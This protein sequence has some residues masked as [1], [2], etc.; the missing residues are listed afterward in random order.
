MKLASAALSALLLCSCSREPVPTAAPPAP[1]AP[2]ASAAPAAEPK[3]SRRDAGPAP[4]L[5]G[6]AFKRFAKGK[7]AEVRRCY[8]AALGN[9]PTLGGKVTI[10]FAILPSG[11][12]SG[13]SVAR[14][15]FRR[16]AVPTCVAAVVRGWRTPF[17]PEEA[18]TVEYP[19]SFAP[20][21]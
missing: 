4:E 5:T 12:V 16:D 14:S 17:R 19:L 10:Q 8:E 2:A 20:P 21:R 7:S 6:P 15:S 11:A 3:A 13:V 1:A 9:D 18:V